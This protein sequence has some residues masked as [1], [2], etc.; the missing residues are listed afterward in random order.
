VV[1]G[2]ASVRLKV[3]LSGY[4]AANQIAIQIPA[5]MP[6]GDYSLVTTV[7]GAQLPS[8]VILSVQQ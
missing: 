8:T 6:D 4:A 7:A 5:S 1:A 3:R 2:K